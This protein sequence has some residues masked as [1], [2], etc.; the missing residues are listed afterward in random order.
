MKYKIKS[1]PEL[2]FIDIDFNVYQIEVFKL[3]TQM[4]NSLKLIFKWTYQGE[5]FA[6]TF[7]TWKSE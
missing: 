3:E 5:R 7:E 6:R 1:I 2:D 4:S